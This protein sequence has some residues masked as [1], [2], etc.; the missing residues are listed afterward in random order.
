MTG[1]EVFVLKML[2]FDVGTLA[3]AMIERYAPEFGYALSDIDIEIIGARPGERMHE[4]L[5]S[6]D[7]LSNTEELEDVFVIHS[8]IEMS[9]YD[10]EG[11]G[12]HTLDSE[13]TSKGGE[14]LSSS[15][16]IEM[17]DSVGVVDSQAIK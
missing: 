9:P 14:R 10:T 16:I 7:E 2:T 12:D 17:I 1:G 4:K 11:G 15:E 6:E 13:Y 5:I 8:A 3:D